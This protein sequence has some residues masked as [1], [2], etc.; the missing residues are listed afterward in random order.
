MMI[1]LSKFWWKFH[2]KAVL[3]FQ[4][5]LKMAIWLWYYLLIY[6]AFDLNSCGKYLC[7]LYKSIGVCLHILQTGYYSWKFNFKG[8]EQWLFATCY[9]YLSEQRTKNKE[10]IKVGRSFKLIISWDN[11]NNYNGKNRFSRDL[12]KLSLRTAKV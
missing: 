3:G 12:A 1:S 7:N 10:H 2:S 11:G 6:S 5:N 4:L 8:I 9:L